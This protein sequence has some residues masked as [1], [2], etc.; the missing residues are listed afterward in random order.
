VWWQLFDAE[1]RP[2]LCSAISTLLYDGKSDLSY[3]ASTSLAGVLN[4]IPASQG[5]VQAISNWIPLIV[6]KNLALEMTL[7]QRSNDTH[8]CGHYLHLTTSHGKKV[9][10]DLGQ[11]EDPDGGGTVRP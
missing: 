3:I 7:S 6:G 8:N 10:Q 11:T 4:L 5:S 2:G 9:N 1:I